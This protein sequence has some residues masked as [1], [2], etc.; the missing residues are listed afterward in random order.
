MNENCNIL[1]EDERDL[2]KLCVEATTVTKKFQAQ[3][4]LED[5]SEENHWDIGE[6][7]ANE[8]EGTEE[9]NVAFK[10]VCVNIDD[11]M[12][13]KVR[14]QLDAFETVKK[15]NPDTDEV[16][17]EE[18]PVIVR[19]LNEYDHASLWKTKLA[20]QK[21]SVTANEYVNNISNFMKWLI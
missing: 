11:K 7:A 1:P 3:S 21:G 18:V 4:R 16:Y 8:V 5:G 12:D 17:E 15:V 2:N 10:Y 9:E 6:E 19:A 14:V 13:I 20:T